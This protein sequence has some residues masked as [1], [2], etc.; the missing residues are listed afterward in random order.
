MERAR[1][2]KESMA[3]AHSFYCR[4]KKRR[5]TLSECLEK[6]VDANAFEKS[7]AAC[8]RCYQGR[9]NRQEFSIG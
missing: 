5:V 8:W 3:A 7:R 2:E 9:K 1:K 6:Y 4:A